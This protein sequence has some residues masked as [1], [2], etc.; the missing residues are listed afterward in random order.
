MMFF[1]SVSWLL[2]LV[3]GLTIS[4]NKNPHII[5]IL[6]D[7]LGWANVEFHNPNMKTPHLVNLLS[8][9]LFL[10]DFYTYKFCAPSRASLLSG[11]MSYHVNEKNGPECAPGFGVPSQM[12]TISAKLVIQSNYIAHQVGKWYTLY[13]IYN[14]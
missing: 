3:V 10:N 5:F 2:Q 14:L 12:T 11:R 7:D 6:S 9:S 1:L 8:E 4:T 13:I